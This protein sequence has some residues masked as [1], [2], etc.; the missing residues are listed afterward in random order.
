MIVNINQFFGTGNLTRDPELRTT[1][2]GKSVGTL[3]IAMNRGKNKE[4]ADLGTDFVNVTVWNGA[5]EACAKYLAKGSKVAVTGRI[6]TGE[7]E[8][9][10]GSGKRYTF[11]IEASRVEFLSSRNTSS[12]EGASPS[13]ERPADAGDDD[14]PF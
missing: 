2:S 11:E 1:P 13:T 7:Y 4:G 9:N 5:A 10:D 12:P 8:A 3:R 14:I 6:R